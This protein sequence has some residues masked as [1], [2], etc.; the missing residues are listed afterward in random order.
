MPSLTR[1]RVRLACNVFSFDAPLDLILNRAVKLWASNDLAVELGVFLGQP[2]TATLVDS[3]ANWDSITLQLLTPG[4]NNTAPDPA[5]AEVKLSKTISSFAVPTYENWQALNAQHATITAT[6]DEM[7]LP[8]GKYWMVV[9]L[10]TTDSPARVITLLAGLVEIVEDGFNSGG[11]APVAA[12]TAYSKAEADARFI[13][14][15]PAITGHT[16]G[17]AT[18]LDGL[19]TT[20]LALGTVVLLCISDVIQIWRLEVGTEGDTEDAAAGLVK[21]DDFDAATNAK[22]W[23]QRL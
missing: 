21:P 3:V 11:T 17:G 6:G 18:K 15:H 1:R 9:S 5:T 16:G 7:A 13:G 8:A 23:I 12:G 19:A 10:A 4:T 22:V 2:S 14:S 20:G